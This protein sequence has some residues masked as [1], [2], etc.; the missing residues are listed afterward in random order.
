MWIFKKRNNLEVPKELPRLAIEMLKKRDEISISQ[1]DQKDFEKENKSKE[2]KEA[3]IEQNSNRLMGEDINREERSFFQDLLN[4]IIKETKDISKVEDWYKRKFVP[5]D[6]LYEMRRYWEKQKTGLLF[7]GIGRRLKRELLHKIAKLQQLEKEWQNRY[8]S[9]L[10][11]EEE[12]R[13][14]EVELKKI[15]GEFAKLCKRFTER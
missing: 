10:D 1:Q 7:G 2:D 3:Y 8:F 6:L 15:L 13:S 4:N 5:Q 11:I 9:L 12:I 14:E